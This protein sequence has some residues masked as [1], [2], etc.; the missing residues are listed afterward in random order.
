MKDLRVATVGGV[1]AILTTAVFVVGITFMVVA[2]GFVG[3]LRL[4]R[5]HGITLL[6]R[7]NRLETAPR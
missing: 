5:G 4:D 1:C 3:F 7:R 2:G 6:R